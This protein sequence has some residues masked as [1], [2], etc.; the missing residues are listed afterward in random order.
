M[1]PATPSRSS[2]RTSVK[3]CASAASCAACASTPTLVARISLPGHDEQTGEH[4]LA[5][6]LAHRVGL[7]GEQRLVDLERGGALDLAVHRIFSPGPS[8][9]R[10]SSTISAAGSSA[11]APSRRTRGRA[12][13]TMASESRVRLARH[14]CTIPISALKMMTNPNSAS[15]NGPAI[16]MMMKSVKI[17]PLNQVRTLA[18]TIALIERLDE[19]APRSYARPRPARRPA[20]T[21]ARGAGPAPVDDGGTRAL[22]GGESCGVHL[23]HPT[24]TSTSAPSGPSERWTAARRAVARHPNLRREPPSTTRA[25]RKGATGETRGGGGCSHGVR[26]CDPR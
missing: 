23:A 1:I 7:A 10:S 19:P 8:R 20:R 25:G 18:R 17:R 15:W 21:S 6:G 5:R 12:S 9:T 26:E 4:L 11:S 22:G 3:R 2:E 14:S 16:S 13:P 24:R